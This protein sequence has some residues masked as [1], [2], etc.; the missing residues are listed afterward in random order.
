M[1]DQEFIRKRIGEGIQMPM[2]FSSVTGGVQTNNEN[3]RIH[4]SIYYILST[5]PGERFFLPEFGSKLHLCVFEPNDHILNDL[6][7]LYV[8]EALT[9]WEPRITVLAVE[10][11]AETEDNILP[12]FISYRINS[13]NIQDNYVYPFNRGS[14]N[15]GGGISN[16]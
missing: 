6:I 9:K 15:I 4:Q 1:L 14:Y 7:K 11:R 5:I 12:V 13:T 8:T 3:N 10:P 16:E 2:P